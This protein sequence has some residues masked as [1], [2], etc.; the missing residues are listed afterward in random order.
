MTQK[1][2]NR[3]QTFVICD[4]PLENRVGLQYWEEYGARE[5]A[6]DQIIE[7][8]SKLD[9]QHFFG[10]L[11]VSEINNEL[12]TGISLVTRFFISCPEFAFLVFQSSTYFAVQEVMKT[13]FIN[14]G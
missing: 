9:L 1:S 12:I 4:A 5:N 11:A 14:V 10:N 3:E 2:L 7:F 8:K 13:V 6:D